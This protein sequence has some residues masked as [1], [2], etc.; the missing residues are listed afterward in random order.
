[1]PIIFVLLFICRRYWLP[2]IWQAL[3]AI[4][5]VGAWVVY[6]VGMNVLGRLI[7]VWDR[8]HLPNMVLGRLWHFVIEAH[9][10]SASVN[11]LAFIWTMTIG[12]SEMRED[13]LTYKRNSIRLHVR[14]PICAAC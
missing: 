4:V 1:M 14:S 5:V 3:L 7:R 9:E 6:E 10:W 12:L 2:L 13:S 11:A 8:F